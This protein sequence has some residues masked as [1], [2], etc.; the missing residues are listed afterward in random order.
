MLL[1][2]P[3]QKAALR[4]AYGKDMDDVLKSSGLTLES[5]LHIPN[6]EAYLVD[7][8]KVGFVDYEENLTTKTWDDPAHRKSWVQ[9]YC[10]PVMGVTNPRAVRRITGLN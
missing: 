6:G 7:P 4:T 5:T 10:M 3:T 2:H 1:V 9:S 8:G